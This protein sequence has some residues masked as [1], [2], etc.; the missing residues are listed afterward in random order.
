MGLTVERC[1]W[2]PGDDAC[3]Q[4]AR[5]VG[6]AI[7]TDGTARYHALVIDIDGDD[8]RRAWGDEYPDPELRAVYWERTPDGRGRFVSV[9][10]VG[11]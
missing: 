6:R 7:V 11:T 5:I 10:I 1:E 4:D 8:V 2:E 9:A 3:L